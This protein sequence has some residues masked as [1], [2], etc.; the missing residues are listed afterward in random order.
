MSTLAPKWRVTAT[1]ECGKAEILS[2]PNDN[3]EKEINKED[4]QPDIACYAQKGF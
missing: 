2:T 3:G 1:V 4:Q